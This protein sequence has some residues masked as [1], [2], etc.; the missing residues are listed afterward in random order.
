MEYVHIDGVI[1]D[2]HQCL[3]AYIVSIGHYP[4]VLG[5]PWLKKH[6]ININFAEMDMQFPSPNCLP[7]CKRITPTPIKAITME[8]RNKICAISAT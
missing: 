3:I 6:N 8:C 5:I 7:H 4:L 2:H 1:G